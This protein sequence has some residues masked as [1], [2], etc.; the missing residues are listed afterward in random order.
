MGADKG[1]GKCT[2]VGSTGKSLVDD[3]IA[4]QS[5]FSVI[6][7]FVIDDLNIVRDHCIVQFSLLVSNDHIDAESAQQGNIKMYGTI[8][9]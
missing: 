2:F 3:V 9:K 7:S 4:S 5:L 6:N 8:V 1:I